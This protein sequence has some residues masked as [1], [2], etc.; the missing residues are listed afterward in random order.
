MGETAA[1]GP[2]GPAFLIRERHG[3]QAEVADGWAAPD[4]RVVGTYL[5]GIFEND[6]FR[7]RFLET[8]AAGPAPQTG[9]LSFQEF[10]EEQLDRLALE[11]RTHLNLS[12]LKELIIP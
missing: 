8:L 3:R 11:M 6:V 1:Q 5:H 9:S 7:R 10:L 2:G 4:G 12:L